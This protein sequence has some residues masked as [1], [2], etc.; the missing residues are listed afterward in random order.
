[1]NRVDRL[2]GYLLIFQSNELIRAQ[3]LAE[4]FEVSERTVYRDIDALCELG[5]PLYGVAGEGYRLMEGYYLP[6]I[7]FAEAEARALFLATSFLAG[8]TPAGETRSAAQSA[9]DKIRTVLPKATLDQVEALR[10]ILGFH[11]FGSPPLNLDDPKFELLLHAI[12]NHQ[13]VQLGYHAKHNNSVTERIVEPQ[14]LAYLEDAWVLSS[15]CRLRQ[16]FRNFSLERVDSLTVTSETFSPRTNET[17]PDKEVR[18]V[19]VLVHFDPGIVRWVREAQ[20]FGFVEE[21]ASSQDG[22]CTM[23]YRVRSSQQLIPWLLRWG[24][25]FEVLEPAEIRTEI[26]CTAAQL[27][28]RH[29][30]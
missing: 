20:H 3:D 8:F 1:M 6:P 16:D 14:S 24:E 19:E 10:S 13:V 28:T 27:L 29:R 23:V 30:R 2:L 5:V 4:R 25:S 11:A 26:A 18:G 21:R 12:Q 9:M 17:S 15:Y 22:G 7:M